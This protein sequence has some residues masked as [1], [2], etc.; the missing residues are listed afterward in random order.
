MW[1]HF[2]WHE[3]SWHV[4][5]V[6]KDPPKIVCNNVLKCI[7]SLNTSKILV[8]MVLGRHVQVKDTIH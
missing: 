2:H 4:D 5:I 6:Q 3:Y 7:M 8:Y 1:T